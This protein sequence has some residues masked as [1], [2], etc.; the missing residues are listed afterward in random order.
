M[1]NAVLPAAVQAAPV[2]FY[3]TLLAWWKDAGEFVW[4][5][6]TASK[7]R[8]R[9]KENEPG[10][11]WSENCSAAAWLEQMKGL[12]SFDNTQQWVMTPKPPTPLHTFTLFHFFSFFLMRGFI[13]RTASATLCLVCLHCMHS[14][15]LLTVCMCLGKHV[16]WISVNPSRPSRWKVSPPQGPAVLRYQV[17]EF[18]FLSLWAGSWPR[19]TISPLAPGELSMQPL[20]DTTCSATALDG[21]TVGL[22]EG[23]VC[24][25]VKMVQK[26]S[27]SLFSVAWNR[28]LANII[29]TPAGVIAE[30][31]QWCYILVWGGNH[32][33]VGKDSCQ[34]LPLSHTHTFAQASCTDFKLNLSCPRC[35]W[36]SHSELRNVPES[37]YSHRDFIL[38]QPA[39]DKQ[40]ERSKRQ[41]GARSLIL[42]DL[43]YDYR[44]WPRGA[45]QF[46]TDS[47]GLLD[48]IH[49]LHG[50]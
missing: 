15:V 49:V 6:G 9:R 32:F 1:L 21:A 8:E 26:G 36:P 46:W 30:I 44:R 18:H 16:L 5:T 12:I 33:V 22:V 48:I 28:T 41:G 3:G 43:V 39:G 24:V 20:G 11:H 23:C 31:Q 25:F 47:R 45:G 17:E 34:Y 38:M 27:C 50:N 37:Q 4:W 14:S 29:C 10:C 42:S 2:I 40:G 35:G 19:G 7:K 13:C